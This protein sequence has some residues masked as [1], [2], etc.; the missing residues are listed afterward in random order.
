LGASKRKALLSH[1]GSVK[2]VKAASAAEL[3]AAKGIGPALASA[4]INH[5]SATGPESA[6]VPAV[7]MTTGEIIET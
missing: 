2:G 7:N 5:F 6:P 1:F 3:S 4:I